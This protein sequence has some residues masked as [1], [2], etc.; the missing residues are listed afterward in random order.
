MK[1]KIGFILVL[2]L[3]T[4]LALFASGDQ[5]GGGKKE[6]RFAWWGGDA[7]HQA[8][9]AAIDAY[10]AAHPETFVKA[11]Y[12]G[13]DGY[14]DKLITQ[15]AAGTG[16]DAFQFVIAFFSDVRKNP[17]IFYDLRQ[18]PGLDLSGW[19]DTT[20]DIMSLD[21]KLVG[22]PL[23]QNARILVYNK[24]L[25]SRLGFSVDGYFDWDEFH[26]KVQAAKAKD[27]SVVGYSGIMDQMYYALMG[28]LVQTSGKKFITD[29]VEFGFTE[30]QLAEG[31]AMFLQWFEDGTLQA[32]NKTALLNSAWSDPEWLNGKVLFSETPV[33]Q[34]GQQM[35][36]GFAADIT[37][38]WVKDGAALTGN[39]V[40]PNMMFCVNGKTA[41]PELVASTLNFLLTEEEGVMDM[42][43]QRGVP[44][45]KKAYDILVKNN[46][47]DEMTR[48]AMKIVDDTDTGQYSYMDPNEIQDALKDTLQIVGFKDQTPAEAAKNFME[49]GN[50]ILSSYK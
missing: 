13:W 31:L 16:P 42:E 8:T 11:E 23:G 49:K 22:T 50:R 2:S 43:L 14:Y 32:L 37:R 21:G 36:Y 44:S 34:L 26:D 17:E 20:L 48:K 29:D 46:M 3:L 27:P 30:A 45:N 39:P 41:Q 4:G 12:Q 6:I 25:A 10:N 7:R 24:D 40:G 18:L 33:T 5:D 35:N 38:Y 15:L 19:S 9:V 28:Y 1:K 47:I